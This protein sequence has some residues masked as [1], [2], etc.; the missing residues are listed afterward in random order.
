MSESKLNESILHRL[1]NELV[2]EI[3]KYTTETVCDMTVMYDIQGKDSEMLMTFRIIGN[4]SKVHVNIIQNNLSE[5]PNDINV[6]LTM[7]NNKD[8]I[9]KFIMTHLGGVN[10]DIGDD[11]CF[12]FD[13]DNTAAGCAL[14]FHTSYTVELVCNSDTSHNMRDCV[15]LFGQLSM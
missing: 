15:D 11:V 12:D 5:P 10:G 4:G 8:L 1:P 14:C 9:Y 13:T 7:P 3:K 6:N 2:K